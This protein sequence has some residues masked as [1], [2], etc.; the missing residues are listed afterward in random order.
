MSASPVSRPGEV[1]V[2]TIDGPS[3]SG[4]GTVAR[5]LAEHL[6]WHLL[7]SGALYRLVAYAAQLDG[8]R[9]DDA[10]P[11]ARV[12]QELEVRFG[13][14]PAGQEQIWLRGREVSAAIRSEQA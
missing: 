4:K 14:S 5:R 6:G 9:G 13:A 7:D 10:R 11:Y 3:G 1:P 8:I 12:A 2:L